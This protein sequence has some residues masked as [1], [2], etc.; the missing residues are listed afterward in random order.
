MDIN[1]H[2]GF[3]E[4]YAGIKR[5]FG[6]EWA[7]RF[8]LAAPLMIGDSLGPV[9]LAFMEGLLAHK[10]GRRRAEAE[11]WATCQRFMQELASS[12]VV[13]AEALLATH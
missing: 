10:E 12:L 9:Y 3:A 5:S 6:D 13:E 7:K 1:E 4:T 2:P 8:V 11:A